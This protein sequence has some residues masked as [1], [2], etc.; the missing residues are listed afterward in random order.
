MKSIALRLI[1]H[2]FDT[3]F[4]WGEIGWHPRRPK[5]GAIYDP[6]G[7]H[8]HNTL[9]LHL[10]FF[11]LYIHLGRSAGDGCL[12]GDEPSYGFYTFD[13][14]IVW[15]WGKLYKSFSWP[16]VT[17]KHERT[18]TLSLDRS[19]VVHVH[20][21]DWERQNEVAAANS[22]RHGYAYTLKNGQTQQR[23]ATIHVERWIWRRKWAP[24]LK[25]V[26]ETI[27]VSFS[28]EVGER[29]GS[30]KGGCLGCSY[31][32]R[33]GETPLETLRRMERERKFD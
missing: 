32:M 17:F 9:I 21:R 20:G 10:V 2:R 16:F 8:E 30:W 25:K 33:P 19:R 15:R 31:E 12:R 3:R 22:E 18:E 28:D 29:S 5:I 13:R 26:Q 6:A 24:F 27:E 14:D 23:V 4:T 7:Y 1:G 11:S